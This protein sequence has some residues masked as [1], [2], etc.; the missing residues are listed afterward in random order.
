MA[1]RKGRHQRFLAYL[2]QER[3]VERAAAAAG[4]SARHAWRLLSDPE[5][6]AK[7][8]EARER[9]FDTALGR[10]QAAISDATDI[11][12]SLASCEDASD[13]ARVSAARCLLENALNAWASR[14]L[15]RRLAA[16]EER[17]NGK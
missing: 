14:N 17:I 11:L 7:L 6:K 13:S 2:L 1:L 15:E 10:L 5:F 16:L 4:L 12:L 3:T 9:V 8:D